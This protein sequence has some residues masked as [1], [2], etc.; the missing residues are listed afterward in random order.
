MKKMMIKQLCI[1]SLAALLLSGCAENNDASKNAVVE[2]V[3]EDIAVEATTSPTKTNE[4]KTDQT[5][6]VAEEK[7]DASNKVAT[8]DEMVEPVELVEEGMEPVYGDALQDGIYEVK[9][10]SSSSMFNIVNCELHVENGE[11]YGVMTMGGTG[12]LYLY[13]GTGEEAV[14]ASEDNYIPFE[15][16][17]TGEHTFTIPVEALDMAI[18]CTAFSK[19][20][21]KW[22]DRQLLFRADSLSVD[23]YAEGEIVTCGALALEDGAYT[24]E[25][26]L[27]GG[28]GKAYVESPAQIIVENGEAFAILVWSSPN[29][30]YMKVED[31]K[32]EL[33]NEEMGLQGNSVFKIPI[34][35]FDYKMPVIADTIAMST[36]HEIEYTL[37]F[38]S[39]T[40]Q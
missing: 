31:V 4:E 27:E 29:Y 20:K 7:E 25:V 38:D 21:E 37:Y 19:K 26:T 15:E 17:E 36:P 8:K 5:D 40:I 28:S 12:Y 2:A 14:E 11:M 34:T 9:V 13:M 1:M 18:D 30:D 6:N 22:Y 33:A 16:L 23:A 24:I 35:G 10:D 39:A 3:K 32:Y